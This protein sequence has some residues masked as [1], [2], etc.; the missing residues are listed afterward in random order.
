MRIDLFTL[1]PHWFGGVF[2]DSILRRAREKGLLDIRLHDFREWTRDRHRSVDDSPY[3]GG[4]GMVLRPEPLAAAL[5]E[6]CGAPG[7]A[8]RPYVLLTSPSGTTFTQRRA[9]ELARLPRIALVCGHYEAVDQRLIDTRIDEEISIG[10]FV[11]T[12]GEIPAMAV[13]DAVAR[14][15]PGVLHNDQSAVEESFTS[16][17]L[18]GPHYTRPEVFEGLRVPDV[19]RSGDHARI[20]KWRRAEALRKTRARRPDL[21]PPADRDNPDE[22]RWE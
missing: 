3:G 7:T 6:V 14:L 16:G 5:D 4:A 10:D 18:E 17:L 21:L 19:L 22:V 2:G 20:A 11:L 8:G 12:G 13:V 9:E 15:I 1:F